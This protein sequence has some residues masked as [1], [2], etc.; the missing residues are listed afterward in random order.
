MNRRKL[1]QLDQAKS[2]HLKKCKKKIICVWWDNQNF[3]LVKK[4]IQ[5]VVITTESIM[6]KAC[7]ITVITKT[8]GIRNLYTVDIANCTRMVYAK[9]V[10]LSNIM[11]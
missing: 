8:E 11:R 4:T 6:P 3:S 9:S 5:S 1:A 2:L 10:I 7:A